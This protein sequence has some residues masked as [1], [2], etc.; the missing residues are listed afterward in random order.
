MSMLP[1][2]FAGVVFA[3]LALV[4]IAIWSPRRIWVK[5]TAVC[6]TGVVMALGYVGYSELLSKPKPVGLEWGMGS[7]AEAELLGASTREGEAIYVWLQIPG[8]DEPRAYTMPWNREVAQQLES[9]N[10]EARANRP[11]VRVRRPFGEATRGA[12]D[13]SVFYAAP[14]KARQLK[15]LETQDTVVLDPSYQQ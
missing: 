3:S 9:A 6:L 7:V 10:R 4:A 8:L 2:L 1:Y 5:G 12:R 11:V 13:Q 15:A 14:R